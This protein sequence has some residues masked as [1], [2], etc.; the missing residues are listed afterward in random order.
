MGFEN[1]DQFNYVRIPAEETPGGTNVGQSGR[2]VFAATNRRG[3]KLT[4]ILFY[5]LL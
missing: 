2:W 5:T 4:F 1:P 3:M